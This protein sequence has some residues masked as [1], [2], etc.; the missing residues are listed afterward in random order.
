MV[1]YLHI[2]VFVYTIYI[3]FFYYIIYYIIIHTLA[4]TLEVF[5]RIINILSRLWDPNQ[6]QKNLFCFLIGK[7]INQLGFDGNTK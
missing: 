6:I 5:S 3:D 7:T 1:F 2:S 4:S